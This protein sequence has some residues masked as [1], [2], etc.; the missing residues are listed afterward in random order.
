M[1]KPLPYPVETGEDGYKYYVIPDSKKREVLKQLYPLGNCPG[2]N[3]LRF[4]V[5]AGKLFYVRDFK[6]RY[7]GEAWLCSPYGNHALLWFSAS[8][9]NKNN[10]S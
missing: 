6:V 4:D 7:D 8:A 3:S 10:E 2:F 9:A 1:I 5:I